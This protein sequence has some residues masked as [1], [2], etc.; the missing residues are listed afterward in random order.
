MSNG[1]GRDQVLLTMRNSAEQTN[2]MISIA[3][4]LWLSLSTTRSEGL[5]SSPASLHQVYVFIGHMTRTGSLLTGAIL[6]R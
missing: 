2:I 5:Q 6:Q 4:G 3:I 1:M